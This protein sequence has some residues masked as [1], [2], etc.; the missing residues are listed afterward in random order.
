MRAVSSEGKG[1]DLTGA[2]NPP[3]ATDKLP[4]TFIPP[5]QFA[6]KGG[7]LLMCCC[8]CCSFFFFTSKQ[9]HKIAGQLVDLLLL[10]PCKRMLLQQR[11]WC[12]GR[13]E[14]QLGT[15]PRASLDWWAAGG[16]M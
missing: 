14:E 16:T 5:P 8:C 1:R 9:S 3:T 10:M 13:A 12:G 4:V 15:G 6:V 11:R 2:L 7:V